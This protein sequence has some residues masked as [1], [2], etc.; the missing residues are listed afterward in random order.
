MIERVTTG[1][2]VAHEIWDST[3]LSGFQVIWCDWGWIYICIYIYIYSHLL[4]ADSMESQ[5]IW[6]KNW[7]GIQASRPLT[8][9]N[10]GIS[11]TFWDACDVFSSRLILVLWEVWTASPN[12]AD[13]LS[14]P[15]RQ[16]VSRRPTVQWTD[17]KTH[18]LWNESPWRWNQQD[19]QVLSIY[20]YMCVDIYIILIVWGAELVLITGWRS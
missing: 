2:W 17:S 15:Q 19:F 7:L 10:V 13:I 12:L 14:F 5:F 1:N 11:Q 6:M 18:L 8:G 20:I 9:A 16:E 3:A 4:Y